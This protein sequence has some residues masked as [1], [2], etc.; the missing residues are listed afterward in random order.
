VER[1]NLFV[2]QFN[3]GAL[4]RLEKTIEEKGKMSGLCSEES[5]ISMKQNRPSSKVK[6]LLIDH[7]AQDIRMKILTTE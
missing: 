5:P 2:R 3:R 7:N 6:S 1:P 4:P